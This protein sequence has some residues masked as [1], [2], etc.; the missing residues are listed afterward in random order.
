M[1]S[2]VNEGYGKKLKY[3][4]VKENKTQDEIASKIG[5]KQQ[6][7]SK[8]EKGE[9]HFSDKIIYKICE[10][11]QFKKPDDFLEMRLPSASPLIT[12]NDNLYKNLSDQILFA[13]LNIEIAKRD[14]RIVDLEIDLRKYKKD[15]ILTEKI[16]PIYVMI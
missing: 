7:Y 10:V 13:I 14:L 16:N 15:V 12:S 3:L 11:F 8:L 6:N 4:R 2:L 9:L 1:T 5:M